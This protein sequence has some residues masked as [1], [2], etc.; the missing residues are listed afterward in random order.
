[1]KMKMKRFLGL[2]L[3]LAL[4]LGMFPGMSLTAYAATDTYTTLKNNVTVV[5][6]ND[7]N[8]YII[9]DNS[10]SATEGTVTLLAAD[11][12]FGLSKFSDNNSSVYSSSKIKA[13]LDA[14]TQEGGAFADVADAIVS[15]DLEDV[16][17]TGAKLYLLSTGEAQNLNSTI[18]NYNFPGSDQSGGSGAWWLRSPGSDP[19]YANT[20]VACVFANTGV[21]TSGKVAGKWTFGVRP[22]L[23]LDLS[24]VYFSSNTF[25]TEPPPHTHSFTYS[26]SGATITATCSA[27]DCDLTDNKATLTI[28]AP[29]KTTYGDANSAVATI[30]DENSIQG[31]AKVQYQTKS[32][33][34]YGDASENA[35]TDAG[36][37]KASITLGGATA[38]VEY[39][40][41]KANPTANAPTGLTATYGQTLADVSLE[42]K[43]PDGNTAGTWAWADAESTSVGTVGDRT[44][45]ANFT[46]ADTTNFNSIQNIDVT[47]AVGKAD[48]PATIADTATVTRGGNTVDLADNVML[49]GATGTVSYEISGEDKGCSLN[50]S[51][52]TSGDNT[53]SVTVNVTVAADDNYNA[54]AATPITVTISDKGTQTITADDVTVTY[55]DTDK[56]VSATTNGNGAISYA[57][58]DGSGDY[59]DVNASTGALTIKKVGTATVVVTAAETDTYAQATKEVTV[60][61]NKANAAAATVTANSRT[62]DGTEKPLVTVTGTPTGG[63][64]YYAL[65][66]NATTAPAD[67]LYTT[68]IPAK[69][70]A[71]TYY[72]WYKAVGDDNHSDSEPVCVTATIAAPVYYDDPT[73]STPAAET[74]TIPVSGEDETVNVKVEVKGDTATVKEADVD[75]VLSAE[76]VGTV[77]VDVSALK[78]NVNEV[79]IPGAMVDKIADAVADEDSTA[80]GM[81][82]KL[83]TGTVSFDADAVAAIA[84]QTDGK[85]LTLHLDDVKVTELT[86]AQQD[87]TKELEV[88]VVLDAYMTSNGQRISDFNGGSATVK[89]PYTLK[90]GQ[91]ARGLVVWYVAT[92]GTRSQVPASYDGKNVVFTVPHFSN[93]VIAY[94]AEKAAAC[95]K[96]DT[97]PMAAFTDLD[98]TLWYHDGIH[99][100]LENGMMNGVGNGKF[101]PT[102]T[103]SRAMIVTILYRLEGEPAVTGEN[104]FTDVADGQWYTNAVIW[105]AEND[106][107][108]GYGNGKFGPNDPITRE[109]LATILYRYA[110]SKGQGFTGAWMFLLDYPDASEISSWADEAMHWCV[111]NGI[112][113]GKD[114]KLVPGGD[115]SRAEA[116]TMLM[117]YCTKI[118]E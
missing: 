77:T 69:T 17:V 105:A 30:T 20:D 79:V 112:I 40:I 109:Q 98:P 32:G 35:P 10:T 38:S 85:D 9:E 25:S 95:P 6:F 87:A 51:V 88:E 82:V 15:T 91:T 50:G 21:F 75:K 33:N 42:N 26:V 3:S 14:M 100:C 68:S 67:N 16:S 18:L 111:M 41:A 99:F 93:Y 78:E 71:G 102:G 7:Y 84:E 53:G 61:I 47:I 52:L 90:D 57:V 104:P 107:V 45:K 74:V 62:Y 96:D 1:M 2:F 55:G 116:A 65:G 80:D 72:V 23:K 13:T 49:N 63:T 58:K 12:G 66:T 31:D 5:K 24:K 97:C 73:P 117:R 110:Q 22:A 101:D 27:D 36:S 59:I 19:A 8:W 29:A 76:E 64:M 115:A 114:G 56:K 34:S 70:D 43:N 108:G 48:N 86:T 37:Y 60:T 11:N 44:F 92:D 4:V 83:P 106:I 54:L 46:P 89:I 28:G 118:A 81:E 94:D 103:T 113:N 39:T